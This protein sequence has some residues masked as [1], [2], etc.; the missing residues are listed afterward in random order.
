MKIAELITRLIELQKAGFKTVSL[1]VWD[2]TEGGKVEKQE[3]HFQISPAS[4]TVMLSED[5]Y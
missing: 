1:N 4:N 3:I 2:I 5:A